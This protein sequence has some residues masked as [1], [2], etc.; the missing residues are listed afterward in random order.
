MNNRKEEF[1]IRVQEE[2]TRREKEQEERTGVYRKLSEKGI[3]KVEEE[4]KQEMRRED[5]NKK[6][7]KMGIKIGVAAGAVA[8]GV[9]GYNAYTNSQEKDTDNKPKTTIEEE[10]KDRTVVEEQEEME[11]NLVLEQIVEK[12]NA[13]Y[14]DAPISVEDLGIIKSEPQ[15]LIKETQENGTT[16]YIGNYKIRGDQLEENQELIYNDIRGYSTDGIYTV[17]NRNN[18]NIILSIGTIDDSVENIDTKIVKVGDKE[19]I[20][21]GQSISFEF[22]SEAEKTCFY[23]DL[24]DKFEEIQ[25]EQSAKETIEAGEREI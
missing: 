7:A 2:I 14:P 5:R 15:F 24:R 13:K 9:A 25:N 19:Y 22:K 17:V 20:A 1:K 4:I 11:E 12:Y 10:N 23:L 21:T 8:L 16:K 6:I 18:K 3:R